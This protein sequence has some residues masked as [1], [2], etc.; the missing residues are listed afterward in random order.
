MSEELREKILKYLD[1][2]SQARNKEVARAIGMEKGLVDKAI[3]DLA[4]EGKIE[5]RSF[6]GITYI[7]LPG[8][9]QT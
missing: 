9:H 4:K 5:Y 6:G 7:A 2:V 8:K 1:T 3:G